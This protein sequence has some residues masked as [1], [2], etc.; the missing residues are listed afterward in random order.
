MI[1]MRRPSPFVAT[2]TSL[3]G[4]LAPLFSHGIRASDE[5]SLRLIWSS[6]IADENEAAVGS[7]R[8]SSSP[9]RMWRTFWFDAIPYTASEGRE[10]SEF[11]VESQRPVL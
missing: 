11:Q 6:A 5:D 8:T 3:D 7:N 2:W 10:L 4:D 1:K 9:E